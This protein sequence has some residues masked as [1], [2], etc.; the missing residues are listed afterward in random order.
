[1]KKTILALILS[2]TILFAFGQQS[3]PTVLKSY[4][5]AIGHWNI[6]KQKYIFDD[7]NY[8]NINFTIQENYIT[9][10]DFQHSIYRII[11]RLPDSE[12]KTHKIMSVK[13][14][15]ESNRDCIFGVMIPFNGSNSNIGIVYDNV[16]YV[17]VLDM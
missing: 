8:V 6:E 7:Y 16:M 13:C 5:N 15:D 11:K 1:M 3:Q 9:C 10:D 17:Y 12:T 4:K 2:T 14:T